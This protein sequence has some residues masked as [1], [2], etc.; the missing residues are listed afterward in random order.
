M[1]VSS[2][3]IIFKSNN[4]RKNNIFYF[5][6]I[7][8]KEKIKKEINSIPKKYQNYFRNALNKHI[9]DSEVY[10][11]HSTGNKRK[12][13]P[14]KNYLVN[15]IILY[16]N[17]ANLYKD[18]RD[19]MSKESSEFLNFYDYAKGK[20]KNQK[21]FLNDLLKFY[22][23]KGYNLK[24]IE[25]KKSDNIFNRSILL[26][27]TFG[28]YTNNDVLKFGNTEQNRK[29]FYI[30]T[31]LLLIYE[32]I[33]H[34]TKISNSKTK[35]SEK[36]IIK[37]NKN[38]INDFIK[39]SKINSTINN[40]EKKNNKINILKKKKNEEVEN[41]ENNKS[42]D[43]SL[44]MS[45]S[46]DE[47]FVLN[48]KKKFN[49][50]SKNNTLTNKNF[51]E[52]LK[53][54]RLNKFNNNSRN[55]ENSS[56]NSKNN[57][58]NNANTVTT[59]L[60]NNSLSNEI[61]NNLEIENITFN[62]TNLKNNI[63]N[64][65][66]NKS[67]KME[68]NEISFNNMNIKKNKY[69]LTT[70]NKAKILNLKEN[71]IT[72]KNEYKNN[73]FISTRNNISKN[74]KIQKGKTNEN[75]T[76]N[77][78]G[79]SSLKIKKKNLSNIKFNYIYN[80][81]N[82]KI[83][84]NN[85]KNKDKIE[86]NNNKVEI[87]LNINNDKKYNTLNEENVFISKKEKLEKMKEIEIND[88][89]STVSLNRKFFNGFPYDRVENYFYK[90]KNMKIPKF[91]IKNGSN[92]HSLLDKFENAV[93]EK[94]IYKI[95]RESTRAKKFLYLKSSKTSDDLNKI[96]NIDSEKIRELDKKIIP[97]LKY[98]FAENI[99]CNNNNWIKEEEIN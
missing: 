74:K 95:A 5:G 27:R 8:Y 72:N 22:I 56:K 87:N 20:N 18:K 43:K 81:N 29:N 75:L 47:L 63:S 48:N 6:N 77:L 53:N 68:R 58:N 94:N 84:I 73:L 11:A 85:N 60:G 69:L 13:N 26:D 1:E 12:V 83:D 45:E 80:K 19:K 50:K 40:L 65:I 42:L 7:S 99:L 79:I 89:Y 59:D 30:D 31:Q 2:D 88:L 92:L 67:N 17:L 25:Y 55:D 41:I 36:F 21:K 24:N 78:P 57:N 44:I 39:G 28:N 96:E 86:I 62:K 54:S 9:F 64:S 82:N 3:K 46:E 15:N 66:D 32:D 97:S 91:K 16:E 37:F 14:K 38:Y 70:L 93:H 49:L 71:N 76:L 35:K 10:I 98:R 52:Y 23:G 90:Y 61:K 33:V 4:K 34:K 51:Y